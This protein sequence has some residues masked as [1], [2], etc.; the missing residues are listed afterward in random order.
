[1]DGEKGCFFLLFYFWGREVCCVIDKM[2]LGEVLDCWFEQI[3]Q[4]ITLQQ[5]GL[6]IIHSTVAKLQKL[7]N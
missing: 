6:S 5:R 1:M 2:K 4:R 7:F 3:Q